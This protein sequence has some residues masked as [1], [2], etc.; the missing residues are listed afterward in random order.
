MESH[1][2]DLRAEVQDA[3]QVDRIQSDYHTAG[4]D[5]QTRTL[6]DFATKLALQ[7]TEMCRDDITQLHDVGFSD[8]TIVDAVQ[9]IAYFCYANRVMDALGVHPEPEMKHIRKE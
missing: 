1:E 8:E 9:A 3:D 6:L 2:P 4:L 7:P 5:A